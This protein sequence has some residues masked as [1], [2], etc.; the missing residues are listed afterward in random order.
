MSNIVTALQSN[1][2]D[3]TVLT[4]PNDTAK[5]LTDWPGR[6]TGK[7]L[8][9]VRPTST[10]EVAAAVRLAFEQ[11]TPIV[12]QSG[13]TGVAGGSV[14]DESGAAIVLSL[15]RMNKIRDISPS[16]MTMTVEAGC[17][18]ETLH[19]TVEAQD[20]FFPLNFG[21]KGSCMI[22]GNLATNAGGQNVVR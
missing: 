13:N 1:F 11:G 12:P 6:L 18:L 4:D 7:A 8:A 16:A 22:G 20:L 19:E 15:E 2:D 5:Y 17:V 14:P 21:A 10:E 9:V 3:A